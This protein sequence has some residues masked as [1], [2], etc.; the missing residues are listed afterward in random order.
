MPTFR[1]QHSCNNSLTYNSGFQVHEDSPGDVLAGAGLG[2]EG[3][4]GIVPTAD[5][6]ITGHLTIRLDPVLQA[7]QLPACIADLDAGLTHMDGDTLALT[8][9]RTCGLQ[10]PC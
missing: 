10:R 7:V 1:S 4:E 2:E 9:E 3:V 5:T 8:T 6:L